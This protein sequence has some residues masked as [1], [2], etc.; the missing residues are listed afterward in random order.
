MS[1]LN[2]NSEQK[3]WMLCLKNQKQLAE[4]YPSKSAKCSRMCFA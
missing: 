1:I 4:N 3:I 2:K